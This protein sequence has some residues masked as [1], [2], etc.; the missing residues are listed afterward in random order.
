MHTA[1]FWWFV[2]IVTGGFVAVVWVLLGNPNIAP[3]IP[4][5][6]I[7]VTPLLLLVALPALVVAV[8][9]SIRR[10]SEARIRNNKS[11]LIFFLKRIIRCVAFA[12][13]A[14]ALVFFILVVVPRHAA[15]H[16]VFLAEYVELVVVLGVSTV[17]F[18]LVALTKKRS[19]TWGIT[20]LAI[21]TVLYLAIGNHQLIQYVNEFGWNHPGVME[22]EQL[23][24]Y[25][26]LYAAVTAA[27]F[28][29]FVSAR[30]DSVADTVVAIFSFP[31]WGGLIA[32]SGFLSLIGDRDM[33]FFNVGVL[34]FS[35]AM[36]IVIPLLLHFVVFPGAD[37]ARLALENEKR[38]ARKWMRM[39]P[40]IVAAARIYYL[41]LEEKLVQLAAQANKGDPTAQFD[42]VSLLLETK[43]KKPPGE[44]YEPHSDHYFVWLMRFAQK[45][46]PHLLAEE[47][48]HFVHGYFHAAL[49]Q[50]H[51]PAWDYLMGLIEREMEYFQYKSTEVPK[52][53]HGV[54]TYNMS[55]NCAAGEELV[56]RILPAITIRR[57]EVD[58]MTKQLNKRMTAARRN[59][60]YQN[61]AKTR[62]DEANAAHDAKHA[63]QEAEWRA[64]EERLAPGLNARIEATKKQGFSNF[65]QNFSPSDYASDNAADYSPGWSAGLHAASDTPTPEPA[66]ATASTSYTLH[67]GSPNAM[68]DIPLTDDAGNFAGTIHA[69]SPNA[70]GDILVS[71]A[72]G[73]TIKT[74]HAGSANNL[75]DIVITR[76]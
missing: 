49:D 37:Y 31:I 20:L 59:A 64:L 66:A 40:K 50:N 47:G 1:K 63:R 28:F 46:Y 60:A 72:S 33:R 14:A 9:K 13:Q 18:L 75:G 41:A 35:I 24:R 71:D 38:D 29:A 58:K 17:A 2:F 11:P 68:G 70:L 73:N 22:P 42:Y 39:N 62:I 48:P 15:T 45:R 5:M 8:V 19:V 76:Q 55:L 74:I 56:Q 34:L 36:M 25:V 65:G 26:L 6:M 44:V 16:D 53:Q 30:S 3:R 54:L 51:T 32:I 10:M 69:G 7:N 57:D 43:D 61:D 23:A 4:D 12:L 67:A 27:F 52:N 21:Y